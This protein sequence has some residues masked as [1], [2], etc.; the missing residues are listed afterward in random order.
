MDALSLIITHQYSIKRGVY[1]I[2]HFIEREREILDIFV[3]IYIMKPC[4]TCEKEPGN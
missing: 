1:Y 3:I 4:V 2:Y